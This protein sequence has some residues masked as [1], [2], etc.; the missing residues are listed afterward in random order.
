MLTINNSPFITLDNYIPIDKM[1]SFKQDW[2][3]ILTSQWNEIRSGVWNAGGHSPSDYYNAPEIFREKGL[4]Y[5]IYRKVQE[6]RKTD[7]VLDR[8]ISHFEKNKDQH[9]LSRYLKLR[10]QAFDPYN[11]LNV[12]KTTGPYYAA[13]SYTFTDDDWKNYHWCDY[14]KEHQHLIDFIE[15]ELPMDRI[16]VV[17]IFWNEHFIPQGFHRD[18]NYFPYEKGDK[19]YTFPHRQELIWFRFDLKRPFYLFDLDVEN[20]NVI[21]QVPVEGY[22]AFF[23]HHQWHGSMDNYPYTSVTVKVEGRFTEEFRKQIGIDQLEY[24][25]K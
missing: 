18:Y 5:Y 13:D 14:M 17:T 22:S 4:L 12:R 9:G 3:F 19:P 15:Q 2:E 10:Y 20:G 1:L 24:Y 8:H 25:Y 23:N 6:D 11:V 21:K 7:V 16:G